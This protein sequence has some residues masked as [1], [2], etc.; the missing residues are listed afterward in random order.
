MK[1]LANGNTRQLKSPRAGW[2]K[3]QCALGSNPKCSLMIQKICVRRLPWEIL[4]FPDFLPS[5]TFQPRQ[6]A[7]G[8]SPDRPF[9]ILREAPYHSVW[10]SFAD[11]SSCPLRQDVGRQ[12]RIARLCR[13]LHR[14]VDSWLVRSVPIPV[15]RGDHG[16]DSTPKRPRRSTIVT[17]R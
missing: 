12:S 6:P 13:S 2:K 10:H 15:R 9:L 11:Y 16:L 7:G 8:R 17:T 4:V 5:F 1:Y 3:N 14:Q